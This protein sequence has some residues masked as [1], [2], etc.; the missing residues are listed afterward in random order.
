MQPRKMPQF[1]RRMSFRVV[2]VS[3]I[4]VALALLLVSFII[5]DLYRSAIERRFDNLLSAHLFSLVASTDVTATNQLVGAPQIGEQRYRQPGTGWVWE[6][7]PA[8]DFVKGRLA[9]SFFDA[10]LASPDV[11]TVPFD[12]T[13]E[14]RYNVEDSTGK[15]LRVLE[16]EVQLGANTSIAR[17]RVA[18]NLAEVEEETSSFFRQLVSFLSAVGLLMIAVNAAAIVFGLRPLDKARQELGRVRAGDAAAL[19]GTFP[20]EIEPLANEINALIDSNKRI[21][22]RARVQ[23]GDLAHALKTPLA[24]IINEAGA[25]NSAGAKTISEQAG[26]MRN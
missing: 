7:L 8:N 2:T 22:D 16:T 21:V 18:G 1:F 4:L 17:F 26:I 12:Q 14:R 3:T 6:V 13:F 19:E 24:V 10:D 5:V 11:E 9:S 23:V 15:M 25:N 20:Q